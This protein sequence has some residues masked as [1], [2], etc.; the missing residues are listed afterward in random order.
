MSDP[1]PPDF[2]RFPHAEEISH[3]PTVTGTVVSAALEQELE[4][5]QILAAKYRVVERLGSGGMGTVFRAEHLALGIPIAIKLM[6]SHVATEPELLRRFQREARAASALNHPNVVRVLDFADAPRPYIVMEYIQGRSVGALIDEMLLP[7]PLDWVSDI[8]LQVLSALDAAHRAGIVHRDLKPENVIVDETSGTR[9]VKVVDFGL[10]HFD[11]RLDEGPTLTRLDYVA[12]TPAYMSPE[13]CRSLAVGPS[14]DLYSL[15][16]LLTTLLQLRPPFERETAMDLISDQMFSPPPPLDR[17]EGIESVPPLLERLRLRLLEKRPQQR[18]SDAV[19]ARARLL[20]AMDPELSQLSMPARKGETPLG[21]RDERTAA[22]YQSPSQRP[23]ADQ[24]LAETAPVWLLRR[25]GAG[26]DA[27]CLKSLAVQGIAVS[28]IDEALATNDQ[29]APQLLLL[30]LGNELAAA[31]AEIQRAQ[32]RVPG[33]PIVVC[34]ATLD[35]PS[36]NALIAAGVA[37]VARYPLQGE[38]LVRKLKRLLRKRA[39]KS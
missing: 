25:G 28:T 35:T 14:A 11:D 24:P 16:C 36:M 26:L 7:P 10:A 32:A 22:G 6:R 18:P 29:P 19:E 23:G 30:D 13:Q 20:E 39:P 34:A 4:A 21:S 17:P 37:D 1:K 12:G 5:G 15:G 27:E 8:M 2:T 9:R 33:V 3:L 31:A 38:L